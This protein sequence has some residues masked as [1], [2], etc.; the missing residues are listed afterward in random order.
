MSA[1][2]FPFVSGTLRYTKMVPTMQ[3]AAQ[4]QK[5]APIPIAPLIDP[6]D[7]YKNINFITYL[8]I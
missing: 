2:D 8:G 6:N 5:N 7:D 4:I 1:K 3:K